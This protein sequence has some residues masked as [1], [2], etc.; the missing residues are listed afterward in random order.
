MSV[1]LVTALAALISGLVTAAVTG[2]LAGREKVADELREI[3]LRIYPPLWKR[4]STLSRWPRT[5]VT[6]AGL[7]R[8]HL[9][10][11]RWYYDTGGLYLSENARARYGDVQELVAA[12][13]DDNL[14][15]PDGE[16]PA[17]VYDALMH[18]ASSFRTALTEDL[19]SRRQRSLWWTLSR[20]RV[21]HAQ[22]HDARR[23]LA[24]A[25]A[26]TTGRLVRYA[27]TDA[28]QLIADVV[29]D[30]PERTSARAG[31]AGAGSPDPAPAESSDR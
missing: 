11:R 25:A 16:L 3:R 17:S 4:T 7:E 15:D 2:W 27:L 30:S 18:S 13:L 19:E 9:D 12:H 1:A 26:G 6:W 22:K 21:H 31:G 10:L 20:A 5:D 23:R 28:D 14:R 29:V 8:F 24:A